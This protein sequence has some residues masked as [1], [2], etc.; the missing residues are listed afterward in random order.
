MNVLIV[1]DEQ[2]ARDYL[3]GL[4]GKTGY[5]V[6]VVGAVDSVKAGISWFTQHQEP[7][8][9]FM[10]I[11]LGDGLCFEIFEAVDV[12]CPVIFT[13]AYDE[14]AIRAFQV[15]SIDYL[16]KPIAGEDLVRALKKF[17]RLGKTDLNK[18]S[19]IR[20]AG[21]LLSAPYKERFVIKI[22]DHLV[23]LPVDQILYFASQEKITFAGTGERKYPVDYS[24]DAL[25]G[26]LNP[27]AFF[28]INRQ[29][30]ICVGAIHD[31]V[32]YSNSRLKVTLQGVDEGIIVSRDRVQAFKA[33]LD[34]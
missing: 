16:L 11:D 29:Y 24:L 2:L 6:I 13:T 27:K 26:I 1:E 14:Y 19:L 9:V 3:S 4:L 33:W 23:T 21:K 8:L 12:T 5:P 25:E 7:D 30:M 15:N 17:T 18:T 10:D 20:E 31:M 28:R 22:G 34:Q 32:S